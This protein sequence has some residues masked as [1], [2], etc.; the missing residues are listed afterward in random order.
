MAYKLGFLLSLFFVAEVLAFSGDLACLSTIKTSLD[1]VAV[2]AS[3]DI[4]LHQ[5]ISNEL[6]SLVDE[7]AHA[8]IRRIG[9]GVLAL[10]DTLV[11]EVYRDYSPLVIS[12]SMMTVSVT[13][14]A[15]IG[16]LNVK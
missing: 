4:S 10:G 3:Y 9:D 5:G 6:I 11:F 7:E 13:R 2:I 12:Q 16:Y 8:K 1:A 15:I 14:S